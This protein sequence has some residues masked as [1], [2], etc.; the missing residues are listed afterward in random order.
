MLQKP[1]YLRPEIWKFI[2]KHWVSLSQLQKSAVIDHPGRFLLEHSFLT[3]PQLLQNTV[4]EQPGDGPEYLIPEDAA[5][6]IARGADAVTLI[7]LGDHKKRIFTRHEII[8]ALTNC[9]T[10]DQL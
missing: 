2:Q 5:D 1:V 4:I 7:R 3:K 10:F 6:Q 9:A 8:E